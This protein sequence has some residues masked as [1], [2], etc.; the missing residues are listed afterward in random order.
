M[1]VS[2]SISG[3]HFDQGVNVDKADG[4]GYYDWGIYFDSQQLAGGS[5][6]TFQITSGGIL[7]SQFNFTSSPTSSADSTGT[8]DY[9]AA[10]HIQGVAPPLGSTFFGSGVGTPPPTPNGAPEP[11]TMLIAAVGALGF[12]GY[13]LRRRRKG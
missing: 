4:D 6:L 13:G 2:P 7:A 9:Y 1:P 12:L 10:A 11:S 3:T 5:S 8:T